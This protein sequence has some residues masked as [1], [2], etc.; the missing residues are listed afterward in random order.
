MRAHTIIGHGQPAF[1]VV[2]GGAGRLIKSTLGLAE[3]LG[4]FTDLGQAFAVEV[5]PVVEKV[6]DVG[7]RARLD[8]RGDARLNVVGIDGLNRELDAKRLLTFRRDFPF[9]KHV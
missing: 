8:R 3:L 9:Q 7:P 1:A 4:D 5:G 6:D 2:G